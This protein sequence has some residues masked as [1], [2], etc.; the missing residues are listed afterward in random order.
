MIHQGCV[1]GFIFPVIQRDANPLIREESARGYC[2]R[3]GK[4]L[5]KRRRKFCSD[6]CR[7]IHKRKLNRG[8]MRK[9]NGYETMRVYT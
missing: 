4:P 8:Y 6:E 7:L 2:V 5:P 9:R 3:C 1:A